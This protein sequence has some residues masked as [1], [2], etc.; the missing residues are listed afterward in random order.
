M[1]ITRR[2][3]ERMFKNEE[4][5]ELFNQSHHGEAGSQLKALADAGLAYARNIENLSVRPGPY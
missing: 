4:I 1:T 2:M 5:R 3:Y